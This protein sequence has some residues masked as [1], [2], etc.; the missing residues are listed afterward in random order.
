MLDLEELERLAK[1]ATPGPWET[2]PLPGW[3]GIAHTV[4]GHKG[5]YLFDIHKVRNGKANAAY[6]VAACD[7]VPELIKRVREL[8]T[9]WQA[10]KRKYDTAKD[11]I[12]SNQTQIIALNNEVSRLKLELMNCRGEELVY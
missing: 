5:Q 1:A 4:A 9:S 8:E 7:A 3:E 12:D 6:I 11:V 2:Y 10:M